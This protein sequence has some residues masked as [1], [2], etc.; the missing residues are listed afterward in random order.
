MERLK[1]KIIRR[2]LVGLLILLLLIVVGAWTHVPKE[3]YKGRTMT[4]IVPPD[5]HIEWTEY[6]VE[7]FLLCKK[8]SL[9]QLICIT[10]PP[11]ATLAV[12]DTVEGKSP[13][14]KRDKS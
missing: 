13:E 6:P 12:P 7:G 8:D 1:A 4:A 5:T 9:N 2:S 11:G 3:V 10:L 14:G